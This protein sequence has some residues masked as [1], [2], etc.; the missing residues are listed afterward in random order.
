MGAGRAPD[1][2]GT[3]RRPH[4]PNDGDL[5]PGGT[6]ALRRGAGRDGGSGSPDAVHADGTDGKSPRG[7]RR[8]CPARRALGLI[9]KSPTNR[10]RRRSQG[11][12]DCSAAV[13][14]KGAPEAIGRG[15]SA[16]TQ[17]G[18]R[19]ATEKGASAATETEATTTATWA[20]A[21]RRARTRPQQ[22]QRRRRTRP[23]RD[24]DYPRPGGET[25]AKGQRGQRGA[26]RDDHYNLINP[27]I[28][29]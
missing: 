24:G 29:R 21:G 3:D 15:P 7:S 17:R 9:P 11:R 5:P 6:D 4:T 20:K 14:G 28:D 2:R 12:G 13:T 10:S 19:A 16:A 23:G 1:A 27:F 26:S 18:T 8:C 25:D 22:P